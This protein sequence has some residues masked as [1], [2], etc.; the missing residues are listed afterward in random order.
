MKVNIPLQISCFS[1][2]LSNL[3]FDIVINNFH[4]W[5]SLILFGYH[6]IVNFKS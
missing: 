5:I 6:C 2:D 3:A 1:T 4:L